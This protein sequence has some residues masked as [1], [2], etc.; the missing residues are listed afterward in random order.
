MEAYLP[1]TT[2]LTQR[3]GFRCCL[4]IGGDP[5]IGKSTLLLQVGCTS[6]RCLKRT[7]LGFLGRRLCSAVVM[8]FNVQGCR[9]SRRLCA[10]TVSTSCDLSVEEWLCMRCCRNLAPLR[11]C[12]I[13]VLIRI[14]LLELK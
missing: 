10:L 1:I 4:Q 12:Q 5:G 9:A 13:R 3:Y 8:C 7:P 6:L 11:L 14:A 2:V